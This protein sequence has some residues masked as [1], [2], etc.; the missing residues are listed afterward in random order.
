M[1]GSAVFKV[2]AHAYG[3]IVQPSL[4]SVNGKYVCQSLSRVIVAAVSRVYYGYGGVSSKLP[5]APSI[6]CRMAMMSG[7]A[8]YY[9]GPYL[10]LSPLEEDE[11]A[12]SKTL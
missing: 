7:V 11:L 2:A 4:L 1:N 8:A 6:G 3:K 12:A 10:Q 5:E 9:L